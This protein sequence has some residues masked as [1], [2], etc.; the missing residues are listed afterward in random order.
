[1]PISY[2]P[3][4]KALRSFLPIV[5]CFVVSMS[6]NPFLQEHDAEV[7]GDV[8]YLGTTEPVRDVL[9]LLGDLKA[10]TDSEGKFVFRGVRP[11]K[12]DLR[13]DMVHAGQKAYFP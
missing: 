5:L 6:A 4:Q 8:T 2:L 7:S 13:L 12:Y 11:G 1:M 10:I 3:F 9:V